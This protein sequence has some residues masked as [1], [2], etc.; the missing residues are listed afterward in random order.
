MAV[1]NCANIMTELQNPKN[2]KRTRK[3]SYDVYVCMPKVGTKV[4]NRLEG[5][6]YVTDEKKRF[7][8]SGTVGETWVIDGAKLAKTYCFMDG[9]PITNEAL[10]KRMSGGIID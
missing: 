3:K 8:I 5:A 9:Q 4:T 6:N 7:I 1:L 2:W 10:S